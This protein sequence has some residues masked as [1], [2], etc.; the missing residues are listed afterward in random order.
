MPASPFLEGNDGRQESASDSRETGG[1]TRGFANNM[2]LAAMTD[3]VSLQEG[4]FTLQ[5]A[6]L[7]GRPAKRGVYIYNG[8]KQMIR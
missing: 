7:K 6:R 3:G 4:W 2:T 8:H 1:V 5:G